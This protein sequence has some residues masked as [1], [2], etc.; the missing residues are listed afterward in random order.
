LLK[1][2]GVD[3][4]DCSSGGLVPYATIPVGAGYQ[5]PFADRIRRE[6][7][8]ATGAVGMIAAPQQADQIVRNG[9]ADLVLLARE[10][11]RDPYW[12]MHAAAELGLAAEWRPQYLR[13]A[14]AGSKARQP[15]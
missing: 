3:L 15:R 1:K 5:V 2:E 12:P 10:M 9:H 6:A 11:L 13:A 7:G 4:I 8:I 14:P